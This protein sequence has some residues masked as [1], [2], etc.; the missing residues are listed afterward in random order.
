MAASFVANL[1]SSTS[2][3]QKNV[4]TVIQHTSSLVSD[5]VE[6]ITK[7]VLEDITKDVLGLGL[8]NVTLSKHEMTNLQEK[9]QV[10]VRYAV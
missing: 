8:A 4:H 3:T 6:D 9:L 7:D 10:T 1:L 5:I 2:V